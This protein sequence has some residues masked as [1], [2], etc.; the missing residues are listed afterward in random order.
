MEDKIRYI[1][2]AELMRRI[3]HD[4]RWLEFS[5]THDNCFANIASMAPVRSGEHLVYPRIAEKE[6][7]KANISSPRSRKSVLTSKNALGAHFSWLW[8]KMQN[9]DK[10]GYPGVQQTSPIDYKDMSSMSAVPGS[11]I[12]PDGV[13]VLSDNYAPLSF[14]TAHMVLV[15]AWHSFDKTVPA[16]VLGLLGDCA[17][18]MWTEQLAIVYIPLLL[19]LGEQLLLVIFTRRRVY[20]ACLGPILSSYGD[21]DTNAIRRTLRLLWFFSTIDSIFKQQNDVEG[22]FPGIRFLAPDKNGTTKINR[23]HNQTGSGYARIRGRIRRPVHI[24]GRISYLYRVTYEG[25]DAVLKFTFMPANQLLES[26]VYQV[27]KDSCKGLIPE[28]YASGVTKL[29]RL[30]YRPMFLITEYCGVPVDRFA[31][32]HRFKQLAQTYAEEAIC[33]TIKQSSN[34]I[35]KAHSAGV[36]HQ[37]ITPESMLI[38]DNG[39]IRIV[40]W[41]QSGLRTD[42]D[43]KDMKSI[44]RTWR[45]SRRNIL[46]DE[47]NHST[48]VGLT[49]SIQRFLG[50]ASRDLM[51]DLESVFYVALYALAMANGNIDDSKPLPRGFCLS[52]GH[53]A[54]AAAAARVKCL[55]GGKSY[56]DDFGVP[57]SD[58]VTTTMLNAMYRFLFFENGTFIAGSLLTDPGRKRVP[59]TDVASGFMDAQLLQPEETGKLLEPAAKAT[60]TTM[61]ETTSSSAHTAKRKLADDDQNNKQPAAKRARAD[62]I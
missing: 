7:A 5:K 34:C 59:D 47:P 43:I 50:T 33:R 42:I 36:V 16:D 51:H 10:S 62:V 45:F 18:H 40:G 21:T 38:G 1:S 30:G 37:A 48:M 15:T 6:M 54:V 44:E 9:T 60:T 39:K 14:R 57:S 35:A 32:D 12:K 24:F 25:K 20:I 46:I 23:T 31:Q 3:G 11:G 19:L 55:S 26:A 8:N 28:V 41:G 49:T 22:N 17:L 4:D 27:L 29:D 58:S 52:K 61:K 53:P 13:F 56:L 2:P